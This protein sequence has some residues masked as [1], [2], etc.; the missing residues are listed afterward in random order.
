MLP[1]FETK[2]KDMGAASAAPVRKEMK[3]YGG[4]MCCPCSKRNEKKRGQHMLP[5]FKMKQK[6]MGAASAA[7][8]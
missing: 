7:P 3:R 6:D 5:L 8:I 4:S 2:R 1:P